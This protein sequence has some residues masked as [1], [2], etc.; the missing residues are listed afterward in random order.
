MFVF[1]LLLVAVFLP[2]TAIIL[3]RLDIMVRSVARWLFIIGSIA[4][5]LVCPTAF[6][7]AGRFIGFVYLMFALG[8]I[9][10]FLWL[11]FS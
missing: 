6:K 11:T 3:W 9:V 8:D 2:L 10:G 7:Y 5:L 1:V 4:S